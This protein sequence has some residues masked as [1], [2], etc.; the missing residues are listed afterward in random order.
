M[1]SAAN[2]YLA[3][4]VATASPAQLTGMLFDSAVAAL[5]G[6]IRMQEAGEGQA[7]VARSIKA[8]RILCELR[9]S[10]D[11]AAGG[12]LA[13][14][15]SDLYDWAYLTLV[16]A[17]AAKDVQAVKDVLGVVEPLASAWREG[18]LGAVPQAA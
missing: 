14:N 16:R 2:Q 12:E 7:A 1:N 3:D 8:Q 10:L 15:L 17:S 4:K 11:H 6:A 13:A 5:R 18:V 9:D